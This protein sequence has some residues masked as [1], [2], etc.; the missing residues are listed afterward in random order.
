[1][2]KLTSE[3]SIMQVR[4]SWVEGASLRR[5]IRICGKDAIPQSI[6]GRLLALQEKAVADPI[7]E[8]CVGENGL[9][10]EDSALVLVVARDQGHVRKVAGI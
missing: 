10:S 8:L 9:L 6:C 1:M 7:A 5:I 3:E 4:P 2:E